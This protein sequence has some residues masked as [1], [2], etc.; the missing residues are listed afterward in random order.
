[1]GC[2]AII[3]LLTERRMRLYDA[4]NGR[5]LGERSASPSGHGTSAH[6]PRAYFRHTEQRRNY[7]KLY[8]GKTILHWVDGLYLGTLIC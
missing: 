3:F 8:E 4:V 6:L 5:V 2:N 7:G 1:M